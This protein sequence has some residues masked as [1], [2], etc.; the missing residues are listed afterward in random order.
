ML[1]QDL[2]HAA[3]IGKPLPSYY[4]TL[5]TVRA[6]RPTQFE[7]LLVVP[8]YGYSDVD[9]YYEDVSCWKDFKVGP[10]EGSR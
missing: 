1:S 10:N 2:P 5:V 9:E 7:S 6:L 8:A 4:P 3:S